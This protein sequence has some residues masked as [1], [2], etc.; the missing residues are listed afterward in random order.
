MLIDLSLH[1]F[2]DKLGKG[3][4]VR[5]SGVMDSASDFGSE[6]CGF[7]SHLGRTF[8]LYLFIIN[9]LKFM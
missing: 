6:G 1:H 9:H 5:L 8:C 4:H 3:F 7:K 2:K